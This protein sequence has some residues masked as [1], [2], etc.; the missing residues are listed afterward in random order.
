M[1]C[2]PGQAAYVIYT[3]G[4]TGQ[5]KGVQILHRGVVSMLSWAQTQMPAGDR[6]SILASTSVCFDL[7]AYELFLPLINGGQCCVI[8]NILSLETSPLRHRVTLLNSVPS[9]AKALLDRGALPAT[10]RAINLAGEPLKRDLVDRLYAST[11]VRQINDLYG[12]SED[13]T[14]STH[15]VRHP[16]G[17]ETIGRPLSNT[18]A[19]ILD[20]HCQLLPVGAVGELYL[21]GDGLSRGYQGKAAMTAEKFLPNPFDRQPGQRMYRTGDL[22]RFLPAEPQSAPNLQY[23]GRIDHQVKLRGFRIELGEIEAALLEQQSVREAVVIIAGETDQRFLAAYGVMDEQT[24]AGEVLAALRKCLPAFMVPQVLMILDALPLTPNG[25]LDRSALPKPEIDTRK[26]HYVPP[27]TPSESL[28]AAIWCEVLKLERVGRDDNFFE[29]GGHSL[30]ATQVMSRVRE[31]F[32][33]SMDIRAPFDHQSLSALA[34]HIDKA[35]DAS[36]SIDKLIVAEKNGGVVPL[37]FAQERLWF[38]DRMMGKN[39]VYTMPLA[40]R[41]E[42]AIDREALVDSLQLLVQRHPAL[43]T[44]LQV[45]GKSARQVVDEAVPALAFEHLD[46]V[47]QADSTRL[48]ERLHAFNLA[49]ETLCRIR[50]LEC[51]GGESGTKTQMLLLVTMHHLIADGWSLGILLRDWS[52][53]YRSL[54]E[55]R[56]AALPAL[57]VSYADYAHWQ[58]GNAG[59]ER[60]A[61]QLD[62]WRNQLHGLPP[63]LNLPTDTPRPAEQD[64]C[65]K[66]QAFHISEKLTAELR[67]L[68]RAQGVSLFMTLLSGFSVLLGR[69]AGETDIAIGTPIANR[70]HKETENLVGCFVN[71]LVMRTRLTDNPSFIDLLAQVRDTALDAYR[72]Q[73][74]PFEHLVEHINPVRSLAHAPL[75]QVMFALQNAPLDPFD[76]PGIEVE[77]LAPDNDA[78]GVSRFDL[79]LTLEEMDEGLSGGMEYRTDLFRSETIERMLAQF[80]ELLGSLVSAPHLPIGRHHY[81]P[82][83]HRDRDLPTERSAYRKEGHWLQMLA[84][85]VLQSPERVALQCGDLSLDES[86]LWRRSS[87]VAQALRHRGIGPGAHLGM[88][89]EPMDAGPERHKALAIALAVLRAGSSL[90][91]LDA[92][93]PRLHMQY[94][95]ER[96]ALSQLLAGTTLEAEGTDFGCG[97]TLHTFAD[98]LNA[99]E[100]TP[101]SDQLC[102]VSLSSPAWGLW[103]FEEGASGAGSAASEDLPFRILSH[104]NLSCLL[105]S[106]ASAFPVLLKALGGTSTPAKILLSDLYALVN[107]SA[108]EKMHGDPLPLADAGSSLPRLLSVAPSG[109]RI[110]LR[111]RWRQLPG[112]NVTSTLCLGGDLYPG[113]LGESCSPQ[114]LLYTQIKGRFTTENAIEVM[115]DAQVPGP[116]TEEQAPAAPS[117]T[118]LEHLLRGVHGVSE[119]VAVSAQRMA[120]VLGFVVAG[121]TLKDDDQKRRFKEELKATLLEQARK[122]GGPLPYRLLLVE[123]LPRTEKGVVDKQA[124]L[125][126]A[127]KSEPVRRVTPPRTETETALFDLWR[128]QFG[129]RKFGIDDNYFNLGGDSIRSIALVAEAKDKGYVFAVKDLFAHPTI[130]Q[131]AAA[132]K[133]QTLRVEQHNPIAP[134]ALI[135]EKE[136]KDIERHYRQEQVEDAFPLSSM[137]AGMVMLSVKHRGLHLYENMQYYEFRQP[138]R[139][140]WLE[141]VLN[142]LV[143]KHAMLRSVICLSLERPL[144]IIL[145]G[146]SPSID[147]VHMAKGEAI[148]AALQQALDQRLAQEKVRGI[149]IARALWR[150]CVH[151][152]DDQ[153]FVLG[154]FLH[155]ALW[156]GWSLESFAAEL[157]QLYAR[158]CDG[159]PLPEIELLPS[160]NQFITL[161]QAALAS[162]QHARYFARQLDGATVPWWVGRKKSPALRIPCTI[163]GPVHAAIT[164]LARAEGVQEKSVWAAAYLSLLALINGT[165][166]I[167]AAVLTQGRPEIRGGDKMI[168]VFFNALPVSLRVFGIGTWRD[169]VR[170]VDALLRAQHAYRYYPLAAVQLETGLDFSGALLNYTNWHVYHEGAEAL[171]PE[172]KNRIVPNKVGGW[173][174]TDYLFLLEVIKDEAEGRFSASLYADSGIFPDT[175]SRRLSDYLANI[176]EKMCLTPAQRLEKAVLLPAEEKDQLINLFNKT[177]RTV[178]GHNVLHRG[179]EQQVE[180]AP[181]AVALIYRN[182]HITYGAL[183]D[184]ATDLAKTLVANGAGPN[185]LIGIC[186]KRSA[187]LLIAQLGILKAGAAYVPLDPTYPAAR[188]SHMI[189]DSGLQ[190]V[191]THSV[192]STLTALVGVDKELRANGQSQVPEKIFVDRL[193]KFP[194][195]PLLLSALHE[196]NLAYVI[197]TSGSTG[198]PKGVSISHKN[199]VNFLSAMMERPGL[200]A[201]DRLLAVTTFAFDISLLELQLPLNAGAVV[202]I[203][204]DGLSARGDA[205]AER[206]ARCCITALQATPIT[207]RLLL[208]SGWTGDCGKMRALVG[209]EALPEGLASDLSSR[210]AGLWNMYGPTETTVWSAVQ[211][212]KSSQPKV[213]VGAPICN[214][215]LYVLD[216]QMGLSPLGVPG[217]LYIGGRGVSP[218]YFLRPALTAEKFLPHPFS[219]T[220]G[221]RLYRSGDLVRY[222]PDGSG[223]M[224]F[225]GRVDHQVKIRGFRIELG[226][227]ERVLSRHPEVSAAVVNVHRQ[228]VSPQLVAYVVL[229]KEDVE[230]LSA[231]LRSFLS[232]H[233]PDYMV[234]A[235]IIELEQLPLTDN[236][237]IDRKSLPAPSKSDTGTSY[238]APENP[239]EEMLAAMWGE[240]LD[241]KAAGRLDDFFREGGHSLLV[242]RL[243]SKINDAFHTAVGIGELFE[244]PV[245]AA[246]AALIAEKQQVVTDDR[247]IAKVSRQQNLPLSYQ[248]QRLWFLHRFMGANAVYNIPVAFRFVGELDISHFL[249]ALEALYQRHEALRTRIVGEAI[250]ESVV[251]GIVE[252]EQEAYQI[253]LEGSLSVRPEPISNQDDLRRAVLIEKMRPFA[254]GDES[255]YRLR[256]FVCE[257]DNS[258]V[259][260]INLHHSIADGASTNILMRDFIELY[261]K[262]SQGE[263]ANLPALSVQYADYAH[264]QRSYLCGEIL[265]TQLEYWQ[266]QLK[267]LPP[268]LPLPLDRPRPEKPAYRGGFYHFN[269]APELYT[270][271]KV[272][273]QEHRA[274]RFMT[275]LTVFAVL[276]HRYSGQ[277]DIAV[278]TPIANRSQSELE[279]V[280]GFFVNTLVMRCEINSRQSFTETLQQVKAMAMGAYAHQETPF[281]QLVEALNPER[282]ISHSPLFQV[283]FSLQSDVPDQLSLPGL[284]IEALEFD[285]GAQEEPGVAR[286]DL[287]LTLTETCDGLRGG[288]EFSTDIFDRDTIVRFADY[289]QRILAES[290]QASDSPLAEIPYLSI[291]DQR[292][293]DELF[294]LESNKDTNLCVHHWI[295]STVCQYPDSIALVIRSNTGL[296]VALSFAELNRRADNLAGLLRCQG[297]SIESPV[298]VCMERSLEMVIVIFAILK[299]GACY[300]PVDPEAPEEKIRYL[301]ENSG[302]QLLLVQQTFDKNT[303]FADDRVLRVDALQ[304]KRMIATRKNVVDRVPPD[305]LRPDNACYIIYTS[306]STGWPKGVV[307]LHQSLVNRLRWMHRAVD[308][309]RSDMLC[310]KTSLGFVDHAAEIFQALCF[311]NTLLIMPTETLQT[312][313]SFHQEMNN[314]QVSRIT[315][316]P[317]LLNILVDSGEV[318][319]RSLRV[320][321]SSGEALDV[322]EP[323][324]F[325]RAFP[326]AR[327]VNVYG[328]TEVGADVTVREIRLLPFDNFV[329][330]NKDSDTVA[331]TAIPQKIIPLTAI[332]KGIDNIQVYVLDA[333]LQRVPPGVIGELYIGGIGLAR[334]YLGVAALSAQ[335]FI[336]NPFSKVPGAR[337]YRTGDRVRLQYDHDG[338]GACLDYLGR[339]DNLVKIRGVRI[340]LE[341]IEA[342]LKR[343]EHVNQ[344]VVLHRI[345]ADDDSGQLVAYLQLE[346]DIEVPSQVFQEYAR[347]FLSSHMVPA[348]FVVLESMPLTSGGKVDRRSLPPVKEAIVAMESVPPSGL[349]EVR[350]SDIWK[351]LLNCESLGRFDDFFAIGGHSLMAVKLAS[352]VRSEFA[353]ELSLKQTFDSP[354][355]HQMA[356][357]ITSELKRV[358]PSERFIESMTNE[359]A[360]EILELFEEA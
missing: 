90:V 353:V 331:S 349:I 20:S 144:Q 71:T 137:Q 334:A 3:S 244:T 15:A 327:L 287:W 185:D 355:L 322:R 344:A 275:L 311:G 198:K 33:F 231:N 28:L 62:Y 55:K 305:A 324:A 243:A 120:P 64:F 310:Q 233:L 260:M 288:I 83:S 283:M 225:I 131:L 161:E 258:N 359:E 317:S 1:P 356:A 77:V 261:R 48:C 296:P 320:L 303:G 253:V 102:P 252:R 84:T 2:H 272:F 257:Y 318:N 66:M 30:L 72:H 51:P 242:T 178:P 270:L 113:E 82:V 53:L 347:R 345:A 223:R 277:R 103:R 300:V 136:R 174:D 86:E 35:R 191:V 54:R 240:L 210:V 309:Q 297:V 342:V 29:L 333:H 5:P 24:S 100:G 89:L 119:A 268:T 157:Y 4:S 295:E 8:D 184:R 147:V 187:E 108:Q 292:I 46:N 354:A 207:W 203:A 96:C 189:S 73:D 337:L 209:G 195:S 256:L 155:H 182:Q 222:L 357:F 26:G 163:V 78:E 197:Y 246:Q 148:E 67:Q 166:E 169:L 68:S 141:S 293:S 326:K 289:F 74:I 335:K 93:A 221:Q 308:G 206:L 193:L 110:T 135:S 196:D 22:V 352:R 159:E 179:F 301:V 99:G 177:Q 254:L 105:Q 299:C 170:K 213:T 280:V 339:V 226:E 6:I 316:V 298:G 140:D 75:F 224:E 38:L 165:D 156:D 160:Y 168:G 241:R 279:Q 219:K 306:G 273:S 208:E 181:E 106:S 21:S 57:P 192:P 145:R 330:R 79:T 80:Q 266:E 112:A 313:R 115:A 50:L 175:F 126:I 348:A 250:D 239:T 7:S 164:A 346:E 282:K 81:L 325:S 265:A 360:E 134:F 212:L 323:Q 97:V 173:A 183:N 249:T 85:R 232:R 61:S 151:V 262:F 358:G 117:H 114:P 132:I 338:E 234:P 63:L 76:L 259:L 321:I 315:L 59:G 49:Q 98:L 215:Q 129:A 248:Q 286:Y 18:Q 167:A 13:T 281:E 186:V 328:S 37:S 343:H 217:E 14:Y 56:P 65:G 302:M 10:L 274:T 139:Q 235:A 43:R 158:L 19:Y 351:S 251:G 69:Y 91:V 95:L 332:G 162:E 199:A 101:D 130:R 153:R 88:I 142:Y 188:L 329:E 127:S 269:I 336:P 41:L 154:L 216:R 16:S 340:E 87:T 104:R 149:N 58:R 152:V 278:G 40:L 312:P 285:A 172:E 341:E 122:G 52:A 200:E 194:S 229:A 291:A 247:A 290:M 128:R 204:E 125:A 294:G 44:R 133:G 218:G 211:R 36:D 201:R 23:L 45:D 138:W 27:L 12:P 236:G 190:L 123:R 47:A 116:C 227:I 237:K 176:I 228:E 180:R 271:L 350:L 111:D 220:P 146:S 284:S 205:L 214:T 263:P 107:G 25:K 267:D 32:Q 11:Q 94:F 31:V 202:D 34:A 124:L 276:L 70:T 143:Q 9:A 118:T 121:A 304:I 238:V 255:L 245:L 314:W 92:R 109:A 307:G 171:S 60:W 319:L 17:P 150:C 42:G 264:W 230:D 39:A